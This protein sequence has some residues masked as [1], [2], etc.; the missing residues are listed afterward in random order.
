[1]ILRDNNI[2][3]AS[4]GTFNCI[5]KEYDVQRSSFTGLKRRVR[6]TRLFLIIQKHRMRAYTCIVRTISCR[7]ENRPSLVVR[8]CECNP[9]TLIIYFDRNLC[10]PSAHERLLINA[11]EILGARCNYFANYLFTTKKR[12]HRK[13]S[14]LRI[15]F[16]MCVCRQKQQLFPVVL[17]LISL[18]VPSFDRS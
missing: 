11:L 17:I 14:L 18:R 1:M 9:F 4:C 6:C 12:T 7:N 3:G 13:T 16:G 8:A 5:Q 15:N 2:H 10:G